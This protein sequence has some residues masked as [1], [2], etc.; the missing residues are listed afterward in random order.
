MPLISTI[1][2]KQRKLRA[3]IVALYIVLSL[4]AVTMVYPFLIMIAISFTSPVD[5][6]EFRPV[7]RYFHRDDVL[8]RKYVEAKY[9]EDMPKYN[10]EYSHDYASFKDVQPPESVNAKRVSD[11]QEFVRT[12]PPNHVMVAH[13]TSLSRITPLSEHLFR[14]VLKKRFGGSIEALNREY[15]ETNE[16]WMDVRMPV[17]RWNER[18][19]Y[20]DRNAKYD[21]FLEFKKNLPPR[22]LRTVGMDGQFQ[23]FL[24]LNPDY[25]SDVKAINRAWGTKYASRFDIRLPKRAPPSPGMRKDWEAFVRKDEG[26]PLQFIVVDQS[27]RPAW[28]AFLARKYPQLSVLNQEYGTNYTAFNQVPLP[29]QPPAP[30]PEPGPKLVNWREFIESA[31]PVE[32][33]S[34]RTPEI[35]YREWLAH[36]YKTVE[37]LNAAYATKYVSFEDPAPPYMETDWTEMQ[38]AK[39]EIRRE[40]IVRNY[41]EVAE[42]IL[43]HGR[44]LLNTAVLC[45]GLL[46]GTLI[47]NPL[48]A[49]A[50][51]RFSLPGTYKI[52][53][54]LLATMAFPAEVSAIPSFLLI[55]QLNLLGTYWAL[56]LPTMANGF[57]IFLLKGFFDSLPKELYEAAMIDGASEMSMFYHITIRLSKP[58]LAVIGL[59][60]FTAAYGS[61]MWAFLVCQNPKMWTLMV[62]LYQMQIWAPQFVI[63][64]ALVLSA[65]PTLLVFIFAQ[66][67]IM[68]GI[69]LPVEK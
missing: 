17:E 13:A 41:R 69:I 32:A 3:I 67:I 61:F 46:L 31:A 60:T 47:V 63:F 27:A 39:G 33:I 19:Y 57:S 5:V 65:L 48:C 7:P 49:Y 43:L 53:L 51:S 11:W 55:K 62:W 37:A 20:P 68:R 16:S 45:V 54:F 4:G 12:L 1:G 6:D 50:L 28:D 25:G 15:T 42:Y 66:N 34:L 26:C 64:A 10:A 22:M 36:R 38:A 44:A 21:L 56:I 58:V 35:L 9:N 23:E 40:F 8:F 59:G 29:P 18:S 14:Q 30:L 2:R 24:R 52:L